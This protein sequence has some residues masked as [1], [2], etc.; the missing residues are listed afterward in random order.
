MTMAEENAD[1]KAL[2]LNWTDRINDLDS[3]IKA[4]GNPDFAA[5]QAEYIRLQKCTIQAQNILLKKHRRDSDE[6]VAV[7]TDNAVV[8]PESMTG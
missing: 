1:L 3:K 4:N 6:V 7:D 2:I 8:L 5:L